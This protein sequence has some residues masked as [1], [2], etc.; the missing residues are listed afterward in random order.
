MDNII[1]IDAPTA[2]KNKRFIDFGPLINKALSSLFSATK[3][4]AKNRSR[5]FSL[6]ESEF[7]YLSFGNCRF[8]GVTP[9]NI[10]TLKD[11][12]RENVLLKIFYG[13]ID[14]ENSNIGYIFDNCVPCCWECNRIK[15]VGDS[16]SQKNRA[17]NIDEAFSNYQ[18]FNLKLNLWQK[19][20]ATFLEGK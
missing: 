17:M 2:Y 10:F 18:D 15:G 1:R 14:R 16:F 20:I 3:K 6:S 19:N 9:S 8:C 11:K 5:E 13:G 12:K 7:I 4:R